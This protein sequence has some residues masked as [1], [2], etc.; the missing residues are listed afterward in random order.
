M[1]VG[2]DIGALRAVLMAN[3]PPMRF[4]Y[5]QRVG[6]AG[7]RN[8][9]LAAALTVC[10]GRSHDE[11][12]FNNPRRIT[13]DPPP[14]PYLDLGRIAIARRSAL[15]EILRRAFLGVD[16]RTENSGDS[17]HGQFGT[18]GMW[19][20]A[21][22]AKSLRG[23]KRI[24]IEITVVADAL[25]AAADETLKAQRPELEVFLQG[26]FA[27]DVNQVL[28]DHPDDSTPLSEIL[29]E[30]GILPMFGFPTRMRTLYTNSPLK[31]RPWP[32]KNTIQR[33]ASIALSTWAPGSEAIKDRARH[34]V[35]GLADYR[36]KGNMVASDEDPL[37]PKRRI[38]QCA[39]CATVDM[40]PGEKTEC[41][42]CGQALA[43][44]GNPG[45]RRF[46][47]VQPLGYRTD[48]K[49]R[50][51]TGWLEWSAASGSRPRMSA[52]SL[53]EYTVESAVVGS[54][55]AQIFE[56]NDNRGPDW[57]FA[58]QTGGHG[59]ICVDAVDD[60]WGFDIAVDEQNETKVALA[61]VKRTDVLVVGAALDRIPPFYE[62]HPQSSK[63]RAAWYSP[64]LSATRRR[65]ALSRHPGQR[66]RRRPAGVARWELI[67]R[68]SLYVG[69]AR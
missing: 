34:R 24:Q 3:M 68:A 57:R 62:L 19:K 55:P 25:L 54:G 67:L 1:E 15:A 39:A 66:A 50:E 12:Y 11:Y 14:V 31:A 13:G 40:T 51:Y 48:Y 8:D 18:V 60:G 38:G 22:R 64:R 9:P 23:W 46:D 45:Y 27:D 69:R 4:N 53:P 59:W 61:A 33:D 43:S 63:A 36:P 35:V 52:A 30:A 6:R 42:V 28:A 44:E 7:R 5:Q 20:D 10:R 58:A 16:A 37:G 56:I 49:K 21:Y 41:P 17:V 65:R 32:P 2:V 29:A 26:G 47:I